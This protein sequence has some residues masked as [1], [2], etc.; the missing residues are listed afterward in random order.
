MEQGRRS[1]HRGL[2]GFSD[3]KRP[4]RNREEAGEPLPRASMPPGSAP[5]Q[6]PRRGIPT[7]SRDQNVQSARV[8]QRSRERGRTPLRRAA[9]ARNPEKNLHGRPRN[10]PVEPGENEAMLTGKVERMPREV[11]LPDDRCSY[12]HGGAQGRARKIPP[13]PVRTHDTPTRR[14][15]PSPRWNAGRPRARAHSEGPAGSSGAFT[16]VEVD[17]LQRTF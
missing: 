1:S 5:S 14:K 7:R 4:Y 17:V 6:P 9:G 12:Q 11:V 15:P 10:T 8:R 13:R 16:A 2:A 3:P